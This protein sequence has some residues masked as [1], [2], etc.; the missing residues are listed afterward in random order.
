MKKQPE[1]NE[2][3]Y[4]NVVFKIRRQAI[5]K[6]IEFLQQN[7]KTYLYWWEQGNDKNEIQD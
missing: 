5:V 7:T 3:V 4:I 1:T 6:L 2:E